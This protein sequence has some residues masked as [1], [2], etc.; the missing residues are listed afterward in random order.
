MLYPLSYENSWRTR[1]FNWVHMWQVSCILLGSALSNSSWVVR[2]ELK[3]HS[4]LVHMRIGYH[5]IANLHIA[6]LHKKCTQKR[7]GEA[8]LS[9]PCR[10]DV[11]PS[12]NSACIRVIL[13]EQLCHWYHGERTD[14]HVQGKPKV[15]EYLGSQ[16]IREMRNSSSSRSFLV[17]IGYFAF[18]ISEQL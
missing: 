9:K 18:I 10:F 13:K 5:F 6:L 15:N 4:H 1:S 12:Q 16:R 7:K 11:F 17:S 14:G 8:H 3:G 2:S